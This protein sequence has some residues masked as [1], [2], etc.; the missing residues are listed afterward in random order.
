MSQRM[1][2]IIGGE[3]AVRQL[4]EDF[5]D[6]VETLPEGE[7]LRQLHL[8]GHGLTHVREEQFNFL[9]GFLGGRRYYQEKHGHMDLRRMHAHV[10]IAVQDAE[11]WLTCMD[12]A[13]EENGLAGPDIERLRAT[14]RRICLMLVN[15]LKAW[16]LP[17]ESQGGTANA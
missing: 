12:K 14:F 5:Y 11:D 16:G 4:V 7:T 17:G 8:R 6:L 2:D 3:A 10:P 13:L 9:T 15:D 1:I